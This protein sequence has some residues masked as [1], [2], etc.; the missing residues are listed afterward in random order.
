MDDRTPGIR[1]RSSIWRR[2]DA[3]ARRAFPAVVTILLML[4]LCMPL[5]LPEQSALLP[6][7]TLT[8]VF[9]W[10]LFRPASMTPPMVFAIGLLL[11][12]LGYLPLGVG[13]LS[14]LGL[15]GL[16]VQGRRVL[17][18]HGFL[19][20]WLTFLLIATGTSILAWALS[21]LL[22]LR[23]L[24]FAPAVFQAVL[25]TAIYPAIVTL[26]ARAHTTIADPGRA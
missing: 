3:L 8:S 16:T 26:F 6:A 19:F 1:L 23:L 24:P 14:L 2:L 7:L 22:T 20:V 9:F 12:L 18:R 15:H 5:G 4:L 25:A 21:S 10:S 13:V 11:D 17:T